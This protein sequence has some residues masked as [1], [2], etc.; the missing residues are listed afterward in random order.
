MIGPG[1][2]VNIMHPSFEIEGT[3]TDID[4]AY[5]SAMKEM[6]MSKVIL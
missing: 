3:L 1:Q 2:S 6:G 5:L 4:K